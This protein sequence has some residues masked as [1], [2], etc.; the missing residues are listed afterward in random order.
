MLIKVI[1]PSTNND[2]GSFRAKAARRLLL[3]H[4]VMEG[5][6]YRFGGVD[7]AG[8]ITP[9]VVAR[10]RE[11]CIAINFFPFIAR[12]RYGCGFAQRSGA[13]FDIDERL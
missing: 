12:F 13:Q 8:N 7:N 3:D 11:K 6:K 9:R 5:L 2:D 1:N 4:M 10:G